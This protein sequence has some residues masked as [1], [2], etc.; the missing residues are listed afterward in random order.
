MYKYGGVGGGH[1]CQSGDVSR[2]TPAVF[3][4]KKSTAEA[5]AETFCKVKENMGKFYGIKNMLS[6]MVE[7]G[8]TKN[9]FLFRIKSLS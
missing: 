5:E 7:K 4:A 3:V 1:S 6:W 8:R 2:I 9:C